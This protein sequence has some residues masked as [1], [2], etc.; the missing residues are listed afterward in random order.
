[1]PALVGMVHESFL[2]Q[3]RE[4][5]LHVLA[6]EPLVV[7]ER[8]LEGGA[9]DVIEQD[10][11]VVGI[12][13]RVFRRRVEEVGRVAD[14]ELIDRRAAGDQHRRRARRPPA[15]AAGA[16]PGGGDG[17]RIA[18]HHRDVERADVDAELERVGRDDGAHLAVAQAALDLAPPV[19]QVAAA[20]A[21]DDVGSAWRALKRVL[22]VRGEDLDREPALREQDQLQ[23]V[24]QELERHPPRFREVRAADPE[25]AG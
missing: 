19:R 13:Q 8:Q 4:D 20:V 18:G 24:L 6:A 21:A 11:E 23:V 16:L 9:L 22:Q 15:G 5:L 17:P 25:L 1:M 14:D 2:R 12:D 10:V 3:H 7:A